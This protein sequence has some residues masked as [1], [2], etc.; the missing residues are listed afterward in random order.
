MLRAVVEGSAVRLQ[1]KALDE[2]DKPQVL[3]R[4]KRLRENKPCC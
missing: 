3:R 4:A 1:R 2:R